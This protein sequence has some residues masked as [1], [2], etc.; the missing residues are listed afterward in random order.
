MKIGSAA[1]GNVNLEMDNLPSGIT[2][3]EIFRNVSREADCIVASLRSFKQWID[4]YTVDSIAEE[5]KKQR[6]A[7]D[8]DN[9]VKRRKAVKKATQ[10]KRQKLITAKEVERSDSDFETSDHSKDGSAEGAACDD[11]I[12]EEEELGIKLVVSYCS[13]DES[14]FVLKLIQ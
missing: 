8:N 5:I 12:D 9:R 1:A 11:D 6:E 2:A 13:L 14:F 7:V 4:N 10:R 3:V